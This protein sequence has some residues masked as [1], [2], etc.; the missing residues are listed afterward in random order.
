[1]T[2]LRA[3]EAAYIRGAND[4]VLLSYR[5]FASVV[6]IVAALVSGIVA[7]AGLAAVAFLLAE[8][9]YLRAAIALVLTV[10]FSF[11]IATLAPRTAVTLYV[12]SQ[13]ALTVTQRSVF[14]TAAYVVAAPNGAH[15]AEL[16]KTF[17]S[18]IGRNRWIISHEGRYLGDAREESFGGAIVRKFFGKFSRSFET[19]LRVTHGGVEA[20]R[21]YRR[22]DATGRM[23]VLELTSDALDRRVAVALATLILGREP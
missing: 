12:D 20:G 11:F 8:G 9:S 22:P 19:N 23:D 7:V 1:M 13:P 14:P 18:R 21:I 4:E 5:G 3:G 16:R 10:M 15:L 17:F 6:G 2:G